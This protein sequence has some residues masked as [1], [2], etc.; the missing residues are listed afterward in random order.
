MF[1]RVGGLVTGGLAGNG[2][3]CDIES[4]LAMFKDCALARWLEGRPMLV[5]PLSSRS[6]A[7]ESWNVGLFGEFCRDRRCSGSVSSVRRSLSG[8]STRSDVGKCTGVGLGIWLI[9]LSTRDVLAAVAVGAP[10]DSLFCCRARKVSKNDLLYFGCG[11]GGSCTGAA[12]APENVAGGTA[13]TVG[14]AVISPSSCLP[15]NEMLCLSNCSS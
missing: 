2:F 11:L 15:V 9:G 10:V 13:G 8:S 1:R 12:L 4:R 6:G 5:R 7:K 14:T 3:S